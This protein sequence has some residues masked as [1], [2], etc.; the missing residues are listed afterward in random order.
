MSTATATDEDNTS[1]PLTGTAHN[2]DASQARLEGS[3]KYFQ[4]DDGERA[5][6][7][8]LTGITDPDEL[9][10]HILA[11][12]AEAYAVRPADPRPTNHAVVYCAVVAY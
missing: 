2:P 11:V 9:K 8:A 3:E 1:K 12:Q 10:N 5:L 4:L 6:Y 7:A